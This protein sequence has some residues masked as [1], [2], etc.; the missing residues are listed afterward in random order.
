MISQTEQYVPMPAGEV[1]PECAYVRPSGPVVRSPRHSHRHGN[2][3]FT[4]DIVRFLHPVPLGHVAHGQLRRGQPTSLKSWPSYV[5]AATGPASDSV[6]VAY[7]M[8]RIAPPIL[9]YLV[10]ADITLLLCAYLRRTPEDVLAVFILVCGLVHQDEWNGQT[11]LTLLWI[12]LHIGECPT[13]S[14][15]A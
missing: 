8:R 15:L 2:V 4:E 9:K 11:T 14:S 6:T 5:L 7:S 10:F 3:V 12:Q 1:L 13:H